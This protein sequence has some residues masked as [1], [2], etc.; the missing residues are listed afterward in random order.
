MSLFTFEHSKG[1][2]LADFVLYGIAVIGLAAFIMVDAPHAERFRLALFALAGLISWSAI[3][4]VLHRFILHGL[5]PF[6]GWH[7]KHHQRPAALICTPTLLSAALVTTLVF[8]PAMALTNLWDACT[9][10]LGILTG[11]L[12]YATTHHAIHYWHFDNV[13][14]KQRKRWHM[15]HHHSENHAC[16]GVTST[17]WDYAFK[18]IPLKSSAHTARKTTT[19]NL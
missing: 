16:Y 19:N 14:L 10:T 11:Y 4:Y 13:W 12:A 3:E 2:Y 7:A 8:L 6:S 17:F 1:T 9:L 15:L 18:S 5:P